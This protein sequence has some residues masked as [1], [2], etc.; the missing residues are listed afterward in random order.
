MDVSE[1]LRRIFSTHGKVDEN[2]I[3]AGSKVLLT[4]EEC[5]LF[6]FKWSETSFE[7]LIRNLV[8]KIIATGHVAPSTVTELCSILE[9]YYMVTGAAP[10]FIPLMRAT[11]LF[12][13]D[14]IVKMKLPREQLSFPV[15][16]ENRQ[17]LALW[18]ILYKIVILNLTV[19]PMQWIKSKPVI[20]GVVEWKD[21]YLSHSIP[22][23]VFENYTV[24]LKKQL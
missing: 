18:Q 6:V 1:R 19:N 9:D 17:A 23:D 10:G 8:T 14:E 24:F 7:D 13:I 15:L 22:K 16:A 3:L 2:I 12:Y 20:T 5:R 4:L 21:E 11:F